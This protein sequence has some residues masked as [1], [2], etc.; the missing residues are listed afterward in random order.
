MHAAIKKYGKDNFT[1]EIIEWTSDYNRREKELIQEYGTLCPNGYNLAEG[2]EDPPH[3]YGEQ[4]HKSV[5]T[6]A[7][8]SAVINELKNGSKSE[9]EI[10]RMFDPPFNQCL[11]HN[12]NHGITHYRDDEVYPIRSQCPYHLTMDDVEDIKWLLRETQ[13]PCSQ[14]ADHYHV[15]TSTIKHINSGR[16]YP[17]REDYPIRKQRGKMQSQP[18]ETILAKRSTNAID[19]HSEMGVCP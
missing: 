6:D 14:I 8:V 16:N 12:I 3:K 2:G 7:Q 15:N 19:T 17:G 18:V 1:L 13:Y 9:A 11:I 5:I 4:H 10:G